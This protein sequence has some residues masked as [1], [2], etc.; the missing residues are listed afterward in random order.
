MREV[1]GIGG[2]GERDGRERIGDVDIADPEESEER[3]GSFC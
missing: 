2:R 1:G 3:L